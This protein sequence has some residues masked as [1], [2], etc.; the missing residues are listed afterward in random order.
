MQTLTSQ[1]KQHKFENE[2][3]NDRKLTNTIV[4]FTQ[5]KLKAEQLMLSMMNLSYENIS[6][7][8]K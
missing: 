4:Y 2:K 1:K 5:E 6:V 3:K 7:F 8:Y